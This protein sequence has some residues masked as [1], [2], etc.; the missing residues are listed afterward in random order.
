M[1]CGT[2]L[3]RSAVFTRETFAAA[4]MRDFRGSLPGPEGSGEVGDDRPGLFLADESGLACRHILHG[5]LPL[6]ERLLPIVDFFP[7][8]ADG[9]LA[10]EGVPGAEVVR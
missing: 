3:P 9:A 10:G 7:G 4:D 2:P 8:V 6:G 5:L 1:A